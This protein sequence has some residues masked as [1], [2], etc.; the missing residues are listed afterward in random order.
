METTSQAVYEKWTKKVF[1]KVSQMPAEPHINY[2]N[3]V[4]QDGNRSTR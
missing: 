1:F 3:Y 2:K 4:R